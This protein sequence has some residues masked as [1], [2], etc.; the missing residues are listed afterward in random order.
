[1]L[2]HA[3]APQLWKTH[4]FN[5]VLA[6]PIQSHPAAMEDVP[7]VCKKILWTRFAHIDWIYNPFGKKRTVLA[8]ELQ[9]RF[10]RTESW[11]DPYHGRFLY[12]WKDP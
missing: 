12:F 3:A 10:F 7:L 1:M 4:V 8:G 6:C 11:E 9:S 5:L 2:S